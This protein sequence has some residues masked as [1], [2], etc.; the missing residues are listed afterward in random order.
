M[1]AI[2][3]NYS[4]PIL[5][6]GFACRNCTDVGYAKKHID[7]EHPKSGPFNVSADNDPSRK[8][9]AV[10]FGGTIAKA[11]ASTSSTHAKQRGAIVDVRA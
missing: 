4:T 11:D 1:A 5:V 2:S 8:S 9:Q 3:S 7:P 10:I 6:N